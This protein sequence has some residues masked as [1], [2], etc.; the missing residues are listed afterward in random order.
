MEN[1]TK[2]QEHS[3]QAAGPSFAWLFIS[4]ILFFI[5]LLS[6]G[7][8]KHFINFSAS[9]RFKVENLIFS[10]NQQEIIVF[11]QLNLQFSSELTAAIDSGVP[12]YIVI[13]YSKPRKG[14]FRKKFATEEKF[15]HRIERHA[16]SNRYLL[17]DLASNKLISF[18]YIGAALSYL[19][20]SY[21]ISLLEDKE[22]DHIAIRCYVDLD[23]LPSPLRLKRLFSSSW[24][25]DSGWSVWPLNS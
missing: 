14:I 4:A 19:G 10:K 17:T 11:T 6:I 15:Q 22:N 18:E 16:I 25:H 20:Q 9:E 12:I 1:I 7:F 2:P 13:E 8:Y 21:K 3:T 23:Q 24:Q 5:V